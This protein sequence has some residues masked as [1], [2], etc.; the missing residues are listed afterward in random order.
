M[1]GRSPSSSGRRS[2]RSRGGRSRSRSPTGPPTAPPCPTASPRRSPMRCAGPDDPGDVLV[3]LPGAEE[4]RRSAR[5]LE[6]IADRE[7]AGGPPAARLA[8]ER[9]AG[10]G[11]A[12]ER[13]AEGGPGDEHRRDVVDDRRGA[14]GR[15]T[16]GWPG[17][18]RRDPARGL[19]TAGARADQPGLGRAAGRAGP[20]GR[21]PAAAS[22]SGPS[23]RPAGCPR[24]TRRRSPASTSAAAALSLHAWG[25]A[26]P[27]R[28]DWFEAPPAG[29]ID[30]AESL[31]GPARGDRAGD[32]PVD[33]D[34]RGDARAAGPPAARP[35]DAGRGRG[36]RAG[37]RGAGG[38]GAALGEGYPHAIGRRSR[39]GPRSTPGP[40]CWPG[41]TCWPRPR[42]PASGP[43]GS[44][45][46]SIRGPP[47]RSRGSATTCSGSARRHF[48][49]SVQNEL[50]TSIP[51][52]P[53]C[54]PSC[55][56]TRTA[57]AGAGRPATRPG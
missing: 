30:A 21:P 55:W 17:S 57:S 9:G 38:G 28:F 13:S 2:W 41:S 52:M 45:R 15:S 1:P 37:R 34:R 33:R 22:G 11:P 32:G 49:R 25:V 56:P 51:M 46:A 23:G 36:R 16:A 44:T 42:P 43:A 29:A 5:A 8:V 40:T 6:A 54:V 19:D 47:G 26:D 10:P 14:D 27:R 53:C 12:T 4:I 48:D 20:G 31:L 35:A 7:A 24:S 50:Q 39:P 3:F 18:R